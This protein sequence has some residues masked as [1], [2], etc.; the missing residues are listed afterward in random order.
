MDG[1]LAWI[2]WS[3]PVFLVLTRVPRPPRTALAR[4]AQF[5]QGMTP[6]AIAILTVS[7]ATLLVW[8]MPT[9]LNPTGI[10]LLLA[11]TGV[12]LL[13][14]AFCATDILLA[15]SLESA[16]R[17]MMGLAW[18]SCWPVAWDSA[19][20][21]N[22]TL[23]LLAGVCSLLP[24]SLDHWVARMLH[25]T[26]IHIV[27]DP[28]SPDPGMI[29]ETLALAIARCR[30]QQ[31]H[32]RLQVYPGQTQD[33]QW[34][35]YRLRFDNQARLLVVGHGGTSATAPLSCAISTDHPFTLE[36]G[37]GP[38]CVKLSAAEDGRVRLTVNPGLQSWSHSLVLAGGLGIMAGL[39]IEPVAGLIAGGACALHLVADQLGFTGSA[40]LFP[41]SRKPAAGAQLIL[42]ARRTLFA[43]GMIWL[44]L[45]VIGW[46]GARTVLQATAM[47]SLFS[48]MF[49]A[50]ALPLALLAWSAR[51]RG[52]RPISKAA[53]SRG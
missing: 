53:G 17:F 48:V 14:Y 47:P 21:G 44:A 38:L 22:P 33:G 23:F 40:W 24:D 4:R 46:T 16:S 5:V 7:L 2:L 6:V 43:A 50:G 15:L 45:L 19:R 12:W 10:L 3:L 8:L 51:E 41:F 39:A 26:H 37:K 11:A 9:R 42:P 20:N 30:E 1:R 25:R 34:H 18:A 52:R 32:I 49:V 13:P 36:T 27:P 35:P 31:S 28:L 29:A